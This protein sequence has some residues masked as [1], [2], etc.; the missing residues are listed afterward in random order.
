MRDS[1]QVQVA[2]RH[3][4]L[5]PSHQVAHLRAEFAILVPTPYNSF[6][7]EQGLSDVSMRRARLRGVERLQGA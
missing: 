7:T 2:A 6:E 1:C 5:G 4:R 3:I